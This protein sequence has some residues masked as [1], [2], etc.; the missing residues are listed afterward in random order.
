MGVAQLTTVG[1]GTLEADGFAALVT[2]ARL[3]DDGLPVYDV[4]VLL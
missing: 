3:G 2:T 1:H 4:G